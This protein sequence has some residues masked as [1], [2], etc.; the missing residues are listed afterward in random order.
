MDFFKSVKGKLIVSCQAQSKEPLHSSFIMGRMA[1]AAL[2]GGAAGIRAESV[3][4]IDEIKKVVNLPL[5]GLI[6]RDYED[7][8]IY[9]TPTRRE[10]EE[11]LGTKAEMIALDMTDR[12]R[13]RGEQAKDLIDA[14]HAGGRLALADIS[15]YEEGMKAAQLGVDAISTTMSGYTPYSPQ[16]EGPDFTLMERLSKDAPVPVFAE[17]RINSPEELK[18]AMGTG[19]FGAIIGSA[20]TRPQL[21]TKRFVAA[22]A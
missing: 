16:I 7:S 20:I 6:K 13:P 22:L 11:L 9:I 17:G 15:T 18:R 1:R 3:A 14:I 19:V 2:E 10:V 5:I 21:I 8:P 12:S 4:D